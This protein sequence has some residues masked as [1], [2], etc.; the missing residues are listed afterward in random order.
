MG[1]CGTRIG[2]IRWPMNAGFA[3]LLSS[4]SLNWHS[5]I[6]LEIILANLSETIHYRK[7]MT[8]PMCQLNRP[9]I[10]SHITETPAHHGKLHHMQAGCRSTRYESAGATLGQGAI[11]GPSSTILA[12][13]SVPVRV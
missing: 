8:S 2:E 9:L 3:V 4:R 12:I 13:Y 11:P 7:H 10:A 6:I 1:G 5:Q